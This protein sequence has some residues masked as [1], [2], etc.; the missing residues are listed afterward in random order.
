VKKQSKLAIALLGGCSVL[1]MA[2]AADAQS[3][4]SDVVV[5]GSRVIR[6]GD[7]SPTP[8]TVVTMEDIQRV[9]PT[10]I[11]D[12]LNQ[13]PVFSS[14]RGQFSNPGG[15]LTATGGS[16]GA[17]QLNM[18]NLGP[19]RN[20]ILFDGNR[21]PPTSTN[22]IVD[23]DMIPQM[24]LQRVDTVTGGAS[25][26]YGSD[27]ITGVVNFITDRKFI[28]VKAHA[29]YGVSKYGDGKQ[30]N[31]GVAG[32]TALGERGHIEGSYEY[33]KDDG[34]PYRSDRPFLTQQAVEGAGSAASPYQ[35]FNNVR[36]VNQP[37]GGRVTNA[38]SALGTQYFATDGVLTPFVNG[39]A[40]TASCCQVG[41]AG[42]Y[43]DASLKASLQSQ[44]VFARFDY[45][46]M[47]N[48]RAHISGLYNAKENSVFN[49][50]PGLNNVTISRE[51]AFLAPAYGAQLL[52]AAQTTFTLSKIFN[53]APR[54][55]P[56]PKSSQYWI[57]GGLEGEVGGWD[58]SVSYSHAQTKLEL[59]T[60]NVVNNQRLSA[61]LDAV[62]NSTGQ[63]VCNA[64]LTNSAYADCVPLN[65]FGPTSASQ[66]AISY[67]LGA[68][69]YDAVTTM[70]D[71]A[72][73]I[74]GSPF[75]TWAGPVT[76]A[77]SGEWR[78][79]SYLSRSDTLPTTLANCTGL[80][81]N[82]TATTAL[83]AGANA[84]RSKVSN[85]VGEG[86]IEF[87]AP[88]LLDSSVG[89]LNVNGALRYTKYKTSG[90]YTTWKVGLDWH[91]TDSLRIRGTRSRDIR[92]PTLDDLYAP[93][94]VGNNS[95]Q[96]L[97][98]GLFPGT[99]PGTVAA[100]AFT[101]GNSNV[102]AEV[103]NTTTAGAVWNVTSNLS[104]AVDGYYIKITDAIQNVRGFTP[105]VQQGCY[106]SGGSSPYCTLQTR[107]INYTTSTAA[108]LV[109]EWYTTVIN[110][111]EIET[112][113]ADFEA[114]YSTTLF[115]HP[116]SVRGLATY[117]P[118]IIYRVPGLATIDQAGSSVAGN[119]LS[120]SPT[121][122][123]T[124][125]LRYAVTDN[126]TVDVGQRWRPSLSLSN[127]SGQ[128]W[129]GDKAVDSFATTSIN[130]AYKTSEALGE[131]EFFVNIQN[132]FDA[133][134]PSSGFYDT[135]TIPGQFDGFPIGDDPVGRF[136]TAGVRVKF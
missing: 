19:V 26:V 11:A 47:E 89:S 48:V 108:N 6:N 120:A 21:V 1:L 104:L 15:S 22:N 74:S 107:P 65:V 12:G 41:G 121:W 103:G 126:F 61:A 84:S 35:L 79:M 40:T 124:G 55:N 127:V 113:G 117:Q 54:T 8:V 33:R 10:T 59:T 135:G 122:R 17:N 7:R 110:I 3:D 36:L 27:A 29:Q 77:L 60:K 43:Y 78:D 38:G 119:G 134:P 102:T 69:K 82:C 37:F 67:I 93:S 91:P 86:A 111:A 123:L 45:E 31:A 133:H 125:F 94:S 115:D 128:V 46:L 90:D 32:G 50:P 62:T 87:D 68:A 66:A 105:E 88:L 49:A 99:S 23:V 100:R 30:V 114:N 129:A 28:G 57:N 116:F 56:T 92:A 80:R 83:F 85:D 112:Y 9:Q 75:A 95:N 71:L 106:A 39:T 101:Q 70:N 76:V 2:S 109:A 73:Q 34:I 58:W 118:H 16:L 96:D 98:T 20:L 136:Y 42:G 81:F 24:L 131:S 53:Q 14:S 4:S 72:G 5:T 130:L 132:L 51:N 64:S 25:A 52:A 97:L 13:L 63:T 44:Q 18:R